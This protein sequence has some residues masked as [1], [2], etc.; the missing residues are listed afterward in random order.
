MRYEHTG[1]VHL[2]F[3]R[4]LNGTIAY[5]RERYGLEFLDAVFRRTARDVYRAIREDLM[6]GDP[7]HLV[8]H[9]EYYL[10]REGGEFTTERVEG[11]IRVTVTRCPAYDYLKQRGLP[12]DPAFRRQTTVLNDALAEGTPFEIVTEE[13]GDGAYAQT[14]RRRR[15]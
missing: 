9:W 10:E 5:L 11:Q 3:H 13:L 14:I 4:T 12:V 2:D 8:E 1:N 7:E 6:R 15:P